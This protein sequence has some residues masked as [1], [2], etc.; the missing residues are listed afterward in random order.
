[1]TIGTRVSSTTY[2]NNLKY[3]LQILQQRQLDVQT[4]ISTGMAFS[5]SSDDPASFAEAQSTQS[6]QVRNNGY[7]KATQSAITVANANQSGM[8][9]LQT[10]VNRASELA[11]KAT[12]ALDTSSLQAM[13]TEMNS[14]LDQVASLANQQ[15]DGKY[16]FGGT[17]NIAPVLKTGT[18]IVGASTVNTYSYNTSGNYN[19]NVSKVEIKAGVTVDN[20]ITA[21]RNNGPTNFGGF[22]TDGT[23][24]VDILQDLTS[25]RNQL[26]AGS[27][28]T[29]TNSQ[30]IINDVNYISN[31]VGITSAKS[32][33][34]AQAQTS[35]NATIL[36]GNTLYSDETGV[37]M[38]NELTDLQ[39]IQ[40]SYS[41][42]LQTGANI[43][44]MTLLNYMK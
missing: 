41:A 28:L 8:S 26:L 30:S 27:A 40:L 17:A 19:S 44:N 3:Q 6:Q 1:M 9:A 43:L 25:A 24:T 39:S 2:P 29:S 34:L 42:A 18:T 15:Q 13:G 36:A 7:L 23:G 12:G 32:S 5:S 35:L 14:I 16:L 22:L 10:L 20:G 11:T 4:K 33:T 21:G 38:A 31:Y 37:N